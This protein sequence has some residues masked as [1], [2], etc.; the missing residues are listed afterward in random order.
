MVINHLLYS[1]HGGV[2]QVVKNLIIEQLKFNNTINIFYIDDSK[3]KPNEYFGFYFTFVRFHKIKKNRFIGYYLLFGFNVKKLID[4][5]NNNQIF[6]IHNLQSLGLFNYLYFYKCII[7]IHGVSISLTR[8][9]F[10]TFFSKL[11]IMLIL[12]KIKIFNHKIIFISKY[13][14]DYYFKLIPNTNSSIIYN[15]T[16][17][18]NKYLLKTN[19]N[20]IRLAHVG[21]LSYE[22]GLNITLEAFKKLSDFEKQKIE[23][24]IAGIEIDFSKKD[25][26]EFSNITGIKII[27]YGFINNVKESV[28]SKVDFLLLPSKNEGFGMVVIEAMESSVI[29]IVFN[30][31]GLKEIVKNN[32]NGFFINNSNDLLLLL[33]NIISRKI[34]L[35]YISHNSYRTFLSR[36]S[37]SIMAYKY[38]YNYKKITNEK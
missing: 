38:L 19:Q 20:I 34:N 25:I 9:N 2:A 5:N 36:F 24:H 11:L 17:K 23:F 4:K 18:T 26:V 6:H 28:L 1:L 37:S 22:K 29:P 7:T 3:L 16:I 33:K 32:K 21:D 31:G 10:R 30:G 12:I 8:K 13:V 15:G 35:K 14:R 27:Y